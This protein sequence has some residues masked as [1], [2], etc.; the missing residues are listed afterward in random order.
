MSI[1]PPEA[2]VTGAAGFIGRHVVAELRRRGWRVR[3]FVHT[4]DP[5]SAV[6]TPGVVRIVGDV[7][8]P[9]ALHHA[10]AGARAVISLAACKRDE[11]ESEATHVGGARNLVAAARA[12]G[13]S[14]IVNVSTQS[15][16]L[17]RPGVY[18]RTK[19]A[20]DAVFAAS[21]L[22]VTTLRPS[23]VYGPDDPGVFGTVQRFVNRLP[24]V[25]ICGNGRRRSAPLH[26]EDVAR[27]SV[28]CLE[29]PDTIGRTYDVGGP[30]LITFDALID[31]IA[32][33][34][35]RRRRKV[36]LP[37]AIALPLVRAV[38][39][40]WPQAPI[41]V[42]NVLGST[43]DTG[44]D[45]AAF[46]RDVG[47]EPRPLARGLAEVF[48]SADDRTLREEAR[49]FARHLLAVE[50]SAELRDRYIAAARQLFAGVPDATVRFVRT[51]PWS[52]PWLDA[53][54]G[55]A[56]PRCEL[57]QRLLLMAAVLEASPEH[58][59]RVL[60]PPPGRLRLL[61]GLAYRTGVATCTLAGG[62]LLLPFVPRTDE[63]GR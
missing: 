1:P 29:R 58:A 3:A 21:G 48:G 42:S 27:A 54:C 18:G 46:R 11:P 14:R 28:A 12:H 51:H 55:L 7:R 60:R 10:L 13:L 40:A 57:R 43:Q 61:A 30:D 23:L 2:V 62:L 35:G 22:E 50:P 32:S 56:R 53:A 47:A 20:A 31:R 8:D 19:R 34:L 38:R 33:H 52:L 15:A 5:W 41:S 63:L 24:V 37:V 59:A 39:T 26:V 36:H 45:L 9:P 16:K 17:P 49:R 44:L 25:P 6:E 4:G